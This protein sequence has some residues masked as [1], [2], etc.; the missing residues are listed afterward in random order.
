M[1]EGESQNGGTGQGSGQEQ[2]Q[3][4]GGGQQQEGGGGLDWNSDTPPADFDVSRA[5]STM[6][7]M[8][9]AER[10]ARQRAAT[11]ESEL[12][13]AR[14]QV[15]EFQQQGL[16]EQQR[17]QAAAQAAEARAQAAEERVQ[18]LAL[19]LA[20]AEAASALKFRNPA[21]ASRLIDPSAVE[22]DGDTPRNIKDLL[23]R[24]LQ[25][26]PYLAQTGGGGGDGGQGRNGGQQA[27]PDMNSMI[28]RSAGRA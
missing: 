26:D 10:Q 15:Q 4:Q 24:E 23:K 22:W 14:R 13:A 19:N 21:L 6:R 2:E 16:S 3:G 25:N 12:E 7:N 1:P 11:R 27:P 5:W 17:A 18:R 9:E 28:R 8:R 20:V